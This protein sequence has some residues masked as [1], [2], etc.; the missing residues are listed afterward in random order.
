[1][2]LYRSTLY[3]SYD[4]SARL[5]AREGVAEAQTQLVTE[6]GIGTPANDKA[7]LTTLF[8][9]EQEDEGFKA[10]ARGGVDAYVCRGAGCTAP[11]IVGFIRHFQAAAALNEHDEEERKPFWSA[12]VGNVLGVIDIGDSGL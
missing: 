5:L 3:G 4:M 2:P 9:E 6:Q 11:G 7:G 1:M 8:C 12:F 10:A